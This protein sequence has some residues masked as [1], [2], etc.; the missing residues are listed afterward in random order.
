MRPERLALKMAVGKFPL[1]RATITME[2]ETVV[3]RAARKNRASQ[4]CELVPSSKKGRKRK[5]INGKAIKVVSWIR[6]CTL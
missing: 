3:G 4:I 5:A 2:E 6:I 1:A